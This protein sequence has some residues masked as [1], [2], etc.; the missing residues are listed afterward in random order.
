MNENTSIFQKNNGNLDLRIIIIGDEKVGKKT[1]AKRIQMINSSETKQIK[2]NILLY[3]ESKEEERKKKL[4]KLIYRSN[5]SKEK[6]LNE[7]NFDYRDK[8]TILLTEYELKKEKERKKIMSIQKIYKFISFNTIKISTF[9]CIEIQPLN[10]N[11]DDENYLKLDEFEKKYNKSIK[12]LINEIIQII[13]FPT[14]NIDDKIEILFLFCFDL[15]NL[16]T[17]NNIS[18]YYNEINK[19]F[20]INKNN[21]NAILIGNKNDKKK[22]MK[23]NQQNILANFILKVNIKY[24]EIS[25]LL[26]FN[27]DNFFENLFY[28][29][30]DNNFNYNYNTNEF[31]YK[32]HQIISERPKF[33]KSQR[34]L[35]LKEHFPSPSPNKYNNNPY[36]YP[37]TKKTFINL[38]KAKNKYNK[39]IFINKKGPLYPKL[40]TKKMKE[41]DPFIKYKNIIQT[42]EKEEKNKDIQEQIHKKIN[43]Y[44]EPYSHRPGYSFSGILSD[45][46]L[47][48]RQNRRKIN[49]MKI[50]EMNEAFDTGFNITLNNKKL[51][52]IK[53]NDKKN[54]I[55]LK[56][57]IKKYKLEAQ[58]ILEERHYNMKLKNESIE[59]EK[60]NKILEREKMY[61]TKYLE[62]KKKMLKSKINYFKKTLKQ[63]MSFKQRIKNNEPKAKFYDTVS[64]IS[65]KKGF[66]FG[67]RSKNK[68][69]EFA[70]PQYPY[71][72]DDFEKIVK[73]Y[74]N[75][76]E[77]K[78]YS[79]RFPKY[80]SNEVGDS[81]E[82]MEKKQKY[83]EMKRKKL[84]NN[85]F[86]E[87]FDYI[88]RHKKAFSLKKQKMKEKEED[89]YNNLINNKYFLTEINYTQVETSYPK[90]S[91]RGKYNINKSIDNDRSINAIFDDE[92]DY[93]LENEKNNRFCNRFSSVEEEHPDISKVRPNY[94]KYS[95][96]KAKRFKKTFSEIGK[97]FNKK[98]DFKI[99]DENN[100]KNWIFRNNNFGYN[101][102]QSYLKTQTFMGVSKKLNN[103]KDNGV[104]G[105]GQYS[106]KGFADLITFRNNKKNKISKTERNN[107]EQNMF[108]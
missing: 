79:D 48:I 55:L 23:E 74:E 101:D 86:S 88:K 60:V 51:K 37:L 104:P 6:E 82:Q 24:Y 58:K 57:D 76:K 36:E 67:R 32:F 9:P 45:N 102:K 77:I 62:K 33:S 8:E 66:S 61:E 4:K 81:R 78:S 31:K 71:L 15:G 106:L 1:L 22:I 59:N 19:K 95:F 12:G 93:T 64:S 5:S 56:K 28:D 69:M 53:S 30:F 40:I 84:K 49:F 43:N 17:F 34:S 99:D 47:N 14:E 10:N 52:K 20:N 98:L 44:L 91:I 38:F 7:N 83:F 70:S 73:K 85:A 90:Y 41:K 105:P 2:Q 18:L 39:K 21:F 35:D 16:K 96:G 100:N 26:Y 94:P 92:E 80:K 103:Y 65:L 75:R 87:F 29:I 50:K 42:S 54:I 89:D 108:Y 46:S 72:L 11:I 13:S 97:K 3:N 25:S 63:T 107:S 27:F 68:K